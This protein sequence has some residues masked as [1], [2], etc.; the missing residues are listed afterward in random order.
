MKFCLQLHCQLLN[1]ATNAVSDEVLHTKKKTGEKTDGQTQE[2]LP[3]RL[4]HLITAA[5]GIHS[6]AYLGGV[7]VKNG[8]FSYVC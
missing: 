7:V 5:F 8:T 2:P 6:V 4:L 1:Y 3:D